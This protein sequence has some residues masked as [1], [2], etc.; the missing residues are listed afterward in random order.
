MLY[1]TLVRPIFE[2]NDFLYDTLSI[3]LAYTLEK[4]QNCGLRIV[5]EEVR[6]ASA[7][8]MHLILDIQWLDE[9][10]CEH[11]AHYMF[12]C[13]KGIAPSLNCEMFT[14]LAEVA[15][16]ETRSTSGLKLDVPWME[17]ETARGNIRYR[18]AVVWNEIPG[19]LHVLQ[20][21]PNFKKRLKAV[22]VFRHD[23]MVG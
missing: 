9:R 4:L 13:V 20:T 22:H 23:D 8:D 14:L 21:L 5:L 3:Q 12:K 6:Y 18:G 2:Y 16:R 11:T 10:R 7:H 19:N 1:K 15:L 17:L